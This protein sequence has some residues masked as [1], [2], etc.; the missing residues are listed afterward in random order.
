MAENSPEYEMRMIYPHLNMLV[1]SRKNAARSRRGFTL[2]ELL[3]VIAIIAILAALLLPSLAKAKLSA[4]SAQ[5][6]SN[7]HQFVVAFNIYAA[8][9][10]DYFPY[11][12]APPAG[13]AESNSIWEGALGN[14]YANTNVCLCPM[15]PNLRSSLPVAQQF[16]DA[17]DWTF[18]S[19]GV[20]GP[21]YA[22]GDGQVN[23]EMGSYGINGYLYGG[24]KMS[25]ITTSLHLTPVFGDAMWDGTSPTPA[26]VPVAAQGNQS[27]QNADM[28]AFALVRH[29]GAK[30]E[31]MSFLD[32]TVQN[33]GIKQE[34]SLPWSQ[35]W[36]SA[37]PTRWPQWMNP[38]N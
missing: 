37:P 34:W 19:W 14:I 11:G 2:I 28:S 18:W 38:Y 13:M 25:S 10:K 27:G 1:A 7:L 20:T 35:M 23:G 6:K 36:V 33:I 26:D 17:S 3:V 5:C 24:V 8:D 15:A 22:P 12:W 21:N 30:P 32:S 9:N 31:N 4:K 16:V 29:G